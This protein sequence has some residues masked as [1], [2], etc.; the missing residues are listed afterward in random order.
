MSELNSDLT[1]ASLGLAVIFHRQPRAVPARHRV[2]YRTSLLVLVLSRFNQGAARLDNIHL[3]TWA[4]RSGRT[5]TML[6]RWWT[7]RRFVSTSTV[8]M[9]PDLDLTIRLALA[10][11]LIQTAGSNRQRLKL[12]DKG[13]LLATA[14]DE[15]PSLLGIEKDFLETLKPLSDGA[16]DRRLGRDRP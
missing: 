1:E 7:G 6:Q 4:A 14:V 16:I 9:D 5:R 10:D 8:R 12:T 11:G 3:L 15:A 2:A 13:K